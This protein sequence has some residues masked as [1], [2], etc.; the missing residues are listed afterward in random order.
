MERILRRYRADRSRV[1]LTG[2]SMGGIGAWQLAKENPGYFRAVVPLAGFVDLEWAPALAHTP[3][4]VFHGAR[5][6]VVPLS[7]SERVVRALHDFGGD[8]R[9]TILPDMGHGIGPMVW[10]RKDL[11]DWMLQHRTMSNSVPATR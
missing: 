5:D 10:A 1:Y 7:M 8:P 9:F 6:D 11:Y 4:W 2:I 3:I